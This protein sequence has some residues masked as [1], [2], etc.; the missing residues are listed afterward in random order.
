MW[1]FESRFFVC[2]FWVVC[3]GGIGF[4]DWFGVWFWYIFMGYRGGGDINL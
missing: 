1:R 4:D 3:L 2:L